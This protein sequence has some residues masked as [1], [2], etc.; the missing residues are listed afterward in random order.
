MQH[1]TSTM[2]EEQ[3]FLTVAME[4]SIS[5]PLLWRWSGKISAKALLIVNHR[6]CNQHS[7]SSLES[8]QVEAE[9]CCLEFY[10]WKNMPKEIGITDLSFWNDCT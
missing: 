10:L 6:A 8:M 7:K 1:E 3:G 9:N 5:R 2:R 4:H